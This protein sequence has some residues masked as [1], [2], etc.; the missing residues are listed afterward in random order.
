[1]ALNRRIYLNPDLVAHRAGEFPVV[2]ELL[3][4][5]LADMLAGKKRRADGA[6]LLLRLL[7]QTGE[8]SA[9]MLRLFDEAIPHFDGLDLPGW[10]LWRKS[11]GGL[12]RTALLSRYFELLTAAWFGVS[13]FDIREFEPAGAPGKKA[14]LLVA[15][16]GEEILVEATS[17]GPHQ[18]DWIDDAMDHLTLALSRVESGLVIEVDGYQSLTLEPGRGW[19]LN[20]EVRTQERDALVTQFAKAA[21]QL[22]L[23]Q[24]PQRVVSPSDDQPVTITAREHHE[25]LADETMVI[26]GW[27]RSGLVP[28]VQRLAS[29]ILDER[30]HLPNSPPSLILVDLSRWQDFRGADYYLR[31]VANEIAGRTNQAMF[32]GTCVGNFVAPS[33]GLTERG[34]LACDP[35]WEKSDTGR[36]FCSSWAGK[37]F[38]P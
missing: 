26:A 17:P 9:A 20:P 27:S 13:G 37:Q 16:E 21:E 19:S 25:E 34:V 11:L 2:A 14:D 28:N 35:E 15:L 8:N 29:K 30:K 24:L 31:Q 18:S 3:G 38:T 5:R 23:T 36:T 33:H 6:P 22:D 7:E 32:V 12:D 1:M 10:R 4:Q